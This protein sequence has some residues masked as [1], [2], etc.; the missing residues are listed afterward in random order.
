MVD[1]YVYMGQ[2]GGSAERVQTPRQR[3]GLFWDYG[4]TSQQLFVPCGRAHVQRNRVFQTSTQ[5]RELTLWTVKVGDNPMTREAI[6]GRKPQ[7][8]ETC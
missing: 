1:L 7:I 8:P 2:P 6:E 4:K 3:S 5:V